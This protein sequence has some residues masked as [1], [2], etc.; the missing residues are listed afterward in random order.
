ML[1]ARRVRGGDRRAYDV[2][3]LGAGVA[4]LVTALEL[5]DRRPG[6]SVALVDKGAVGTSGSTALAQGGLAA[7]VGP[8]D[9][10]ALHAAD[11]VAAGDGLVDPQ[12]AAVLAREAPARVRD[13]V[14]RGTRFDRDDDGRLAVAREGGQS[15]ARSVR[16]ADAT[17]AAIFAA[18]RAGALGRVVRLEG[19]ACALAIGGEPARV[20]GAWLMIDDR[21][22]DASGPA[23]EAG[24]VLVTGR[25]VVLATGGCG[26][27][28]AATTNRGDAT[29]DGVAL[30]AAAGASL[31]DLEFVQFHPTGL[32]GGGMRR[33]L[34]TEALRGAGA[35]LVDA[36]GHR[37]MPERHPDAELAPRHVVTRVILDQAGGA[38]LDATR[39][40]AG[41]LAAEFPTALAGARAHGYDM[42]TEPVPV[43][44]CQHYMVGGVMTDLW[45]RTSLPGLWA[46][47]EVAS[48]GVHGANRMAGNSLAQACVFGRR[49]GRSVAD[50]ID[51][52]PEV[53]ADLDPP[54]A[55]AL[56]ETDVAALHLDVRLAM[57]AGAGPVR[58]ADSLEAA[59]KALDAVAAALGDGPPA[60]QRDAIELAHALVAG[61]LI[62]RSARLRTESRGVHWRDDAPGTRSE[63]EGVRLQVRGTGPGRP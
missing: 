22:A 46:A 7:A 44:P 10:P 16:A 55:G 54:P 14:A 28:Y 48:T 37:F 59:D 35:V 15:V 9:S 25:A 40:S 53:A 13:L 63:W 56:A 24:L 52:V 31:V 18:L 62:V 5:L 43:E 27:L 57:T 23:Q 30:A 11:T 29:A 21:D 45:G 47:G 41:R 32:A 2:V 8:D 38:W 1:A 49:A 34:L 17:G 3:V 61:R 12:A 4:G 58:T 26:G 50:E 36:D 60:G 51:A 19:T 20:Q 33:P 39:L 6:L 42:A